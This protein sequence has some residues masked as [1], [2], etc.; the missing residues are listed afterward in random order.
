MKN[1]FGA[2]VANAAHEIAAAYWEARHP[3]GYPRAGQMQ[4]PMRATDDIRVLHPDYD[5]ETC[6]YCRRTYAYPVEQHHTT[7]ECEFWEQWEET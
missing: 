6:K 1:L 7:T 5:G 4:R 3:K 2:Y